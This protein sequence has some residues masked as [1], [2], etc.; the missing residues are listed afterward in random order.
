M[1]NKNTPMST[2]STMSRMMTT[3]RPREFFFFL[4]GRDAVPLDTPAAG[5]EPVDF[6]A[7]AF[8]EEDGF[9]ADVPDGFLE[10][11]EDFF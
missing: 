2:M 5:R 4:T 6:F 11:A 8:P 7:G 9:L 1:K 10:P 3:R